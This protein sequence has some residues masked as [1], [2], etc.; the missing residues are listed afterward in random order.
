MI[1]LKNSTEKQ[2]C[3]IPKNMGY[4]GKKTYK[5][6]VEYQKSLIEPIT[7]T[8]NGVYENENGYSPI[9]VNIP[10]GGTTITENG[11][12]D[13]RNGYVAKSDEEIGNYWRMQGGGFVFQLGSAYNNIKMQVLFKP[14]NEVGEYFPDLIRGIIG[15]YAQNFYIAEE[16]EN[17]YKIFACVGDW[18]SEHIEITNDWHLLSLS[19]TEFAIDGK[20]VGIV[21]DD[22]E[23]A[24]TSIF[25]NGLY[26]TNSNNYFYP[27]LGEYSDVKIWCDDVLLFDCV[28]FYEGNQNGEY[29]YLNKVDNQ[30]VTN[31]WR[32]VNNWLNIGYTND[33]K[34]KNV[35]ALDYIDVQVFGG[36]VNL[37]NKDVVLENE[38]VVNIKANEEGVDGFRE[39]N[40]DATP[41]KNKVYQY[42]YED[43]LM[44][45][46]DCEN[47]TELNV[48]ENGVYEGAFNRVDVNVPQEG[49]NCNLGELRTNF[50]DMDGTGRWWR[51]ANADGLDGY[52]YVEINAN[53]YGGQKFNE[54]YEQ[55][56]ND[57]QANCGEGGGCVLEHL[58][59]N[60][61][62]YYEPKAQEFDYLTVREN[63]AFDTGVK[64]VDNTT[65]EILFN[66][67]DSDSNIP[68]LIGCEDEDW[69]SSTFAVRWFGGTLAVKIG[70]QEINIPM[71]AEDE[72]M[73]FHK[74]KFGRYEGVW[75][76]DNFIEPFYDTEWILTQN[77][78]YIGAMHNRTNGDANGVW[79]P[80]NGY[81]GNVKIYGEKNG[82]VRDFTF[83]CGDFGRWGEYWAEGDI[84]PNLMGDGG[85]ILSCCKQYGDKPFDGY[86]SVSV[87][88]DVEPYKE[89]GRQEILNNLRPINITENGHYDIYEL[90]NVKYLNFGQDDNVW[91]STDKNIT[92]DS[93]IEL[94]FMLANENHNENTLIATPNGFKVTFSGG[95]LR[96]IIGDKNT[97]NI[98]YNGEPFA[99]NYVKVNKEGITCGE[100]FVDWSGNDWY[101]NLWNYLTD[102]ELFIGTDTNN[103]EYNFKNG[104]LW[105]KINGVLYEAVEDNIFRADDG[106]TFTKEG[107]GYAPI[108]YADVNKYDGS[109]WREI[110]VNVPT[111]PLT[112]LNVTENGVY[113]GAYNKVNVNVDISYPVFNKLSAEFELYSYYRLEP[114]DSNALV[115]KSGNKTE[116]II[117]STEGISYLWSN[118]N[119][120]KCVLTIKEN[121]FSNLSSIRK[122]KLYTITT[123]DE[124]AFK[125]AT[126]LE[127]IEYDFSGVGFI[128]GYFTTIKEEAFS[129][130]SKLSKIIW[131][132]GNPEFEGDNI[133][134]GLPENGVLYLNEGVD[135]TSWLSKLPNGWTVERL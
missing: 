71:G 37:I 117:T 94:A 10:F 129:G 66:T 27:N 3:F 115:N 113:E 42:G 38:V 87:N 95:G 5:D 70:T 20:V 8:D 112:E 63:S 128:S 31:N 135:E 43:G 100:N 102:G 17:P 24:V 85:A 101:E 69:N 73:K 89:E 16:V 81:I 79:R 104:L 2:D 55:G 49:G 47:L 82:E 84:L 45:C 88:I 46:P 97:W 125:N 111:T 28:Y 106:Q 62:G 91:F 67:G 19:K 50:E 34:L 96:G 22:F 107:N 59:V 86:S 57:G 65:I 52:D 126:S 35:R 64:L 4:V 134:N 60:E 41:L 131:R 12:Y 133:F 33:Y 121:A 23:V 99:V 83:S 40:I 26:D 14:S 90:K 78:I 124:R 80:W 122:V 51:G 56:Y 25:L 74:L 1:Y 123:I 29:G 21:P 109:G 30:L 58:E 13:T 75:L 114:L 44:N 108:I 18:Q 105:V 15:S 61:N 110:N 77:T 127:E 119:E 72:A 32:V 9:D 98:G 92:K 36:D 93:E 11:I 68:T 39:V 103:S 76:D 130:C 116:H 7:I 6:G 48:T 54:G 53:E 118:A 120:E 132:L